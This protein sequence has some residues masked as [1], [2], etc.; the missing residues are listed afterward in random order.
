MAD[1]RLVDA[2]ELEAHLRNI[3]DKCD[4]SSQYG[5]CERIAYSIAADAV[6]NAPTMDSSTQW[7]CVDDKLPELHWESEDDL[8]FWPGGGKW[9]SEWVV[10]QYF[11]YDGELCFA[12]ARYYEY[13]NTRDDHT[14]KEFDGPGLNPWDTIVCWKYI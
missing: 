4:T 12:A 6:R 8:E 14:S 5:A 2:I 7:T 11:N 3:A 13:G 9:A 1:I 10:V